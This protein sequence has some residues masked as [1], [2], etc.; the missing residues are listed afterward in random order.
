MNESIRMIVVLAVIAMVSG[1]LLAWVYDWTGEIIAQNQLQEMMASIQEVLPKATRIER[2][3]SAPSTLVEEDPDQAREVE[4][5]TTEMFIGFDDS[6]NPVGYAYVGEGPGYGGAVRVLVGV[7]GSNGQI[8]GISIVSHSETPGLGSR[9]EEESFR[10]QFVGKTLDD[11]IALGTDIDVLTG[12][13]V[14]S[15]AVVDAVRGGFEDASVAY[16]RSR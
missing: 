6:D 8:L 4:Q 7:D 14:S 16:E 1:G 13:T 9:I 11:P 5:T 3:G 12:A 15:Q 2:L 10:R